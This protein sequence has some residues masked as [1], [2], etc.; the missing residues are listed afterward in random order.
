MVV[1]GG[2]VGVV[3]EVVVVVGGGWEKGLEEEVDGWSGMSLIMMARATP[4]RDEILFRRRET[5]LTVEFRT[6]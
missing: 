6:P 2:G 5:F 3:D 1:G 4:P